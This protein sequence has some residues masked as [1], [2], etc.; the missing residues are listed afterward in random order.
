MSAQPLQVIHLTV[1][2]RHGSTYI[3]SEDMPGLW[4]W[5]PDP[6]K[7]FHDIP[8]ALQELYKFKSGTDVVARP[9]T[10][11]ERLARHLGAELEPDT[12]EIFPVSSV[13]QDGVNG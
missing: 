5:G 3:S 4:L 13:K 2:E 10:A 8:I 12:Y 9:K 11:G 6:E 1:E 7:V